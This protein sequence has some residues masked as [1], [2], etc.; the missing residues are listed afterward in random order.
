MLG[1]SGTGVAE[2]VQVSPVPDLTD[3]SSLGIRESDGQSILRK[4]NT[5]RWSALSH[6]NLED[7]VIG[8][9]RRPIRP[10]VTEEQVRAELDRHHQDLDREQHQAVIG[11]L[12]ADRAMAL[13]TAPA[14]A[15]K[16][17]TIAAAAKVWHALT[18][19]RL[20]GDPSKTPW[21]APA[22]PRSC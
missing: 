22:H 3:V 13:L 6:L 8:E 10:L 4:P 5:L 18:G 19:G 11:L 20:L 12:T 14:G 9:A 15:G 1:I 7:Q 16:T 2:V 21:P 17:R